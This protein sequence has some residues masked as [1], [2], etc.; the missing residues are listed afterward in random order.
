M[1]SD[2]TP[3]HVPSVLRSAVSRRALLGGSMAL[4]LGALLTACGQ[5]E[6]ALLAAPSG[7]PQRGGKLR[8]GLAG[9]GAADSLDPHSPVS[10]TDIARVVNLY[11]PLFYR[12]ED[13]VLTPLLALSAKPD[14][15]AK[16]WT[17][18]LRPDV[19]F[20]DG[21]PVTAE[22][23]VASFARITNPKDPKTAA[24]D[25][26][27]LDEVAVISD[28][29]LEFRLNT[30]SATLDDSLGQYSVGIV[31]ADFDIKNPIGTGPFKVSSFDPGRQSVFSANEYYWREGEPFLDELVILN[32]SDDDALINSLLSTQVDAIG[33]IPLALLEVIG[34]DPRI[35]ILNSQT[36][37]WLP[38]TMRVD[39]KPFDDVRVRQAFRLAVDREQMI[40]QVLSGNGTVGNDLYSPFDPGYAKNLPQRTQDVAAARQLLAEAGYPDG[41]DIELVTAPIQ[42]G[43]VEAAQVFAQQAAASGI[44]V[45]IRR[46]DSTTFFGDDYLSWTFAQDFWYT[47]NFLPQVS[48]SSLKSSPFNETHWDDPE[49]NALVK[50]AV[51]TVDEAKRNALIAQAQKIEYD[52]GGYIIWGYPN[53]ADAFQSYVAGLI[54]S[55]TGLALSGFEFRRAWIGVSK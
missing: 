5:G 52:R 1:I 33:Q 27:I 15:E 53:Q 54:P 41:L 32:F 7:P 42:S 22:D 45:K 31:P 20:H 10:T 12:N 29:V 30:P 43:A 34:A 4:G 3:H 11:E 37:A 39:K 14:A 19:K 40:E 50:K 38:F 49:F 46:V 13:F 23:V 17:V 28:T 36:G 24:A 44:R 26:G 8:V 48:N 18:E 47:R 9:G 16:T 2:R 35:S 21:R 55:K 6:T 51:V 25:L